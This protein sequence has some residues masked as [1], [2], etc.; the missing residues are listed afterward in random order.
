MTH[1]THLFSPTAR[2]RHRGRSRCGT[3]HDPSRHSDTPTC[4]IC[5]PHARAQALS[6]P[7][8]DHGGHVDFYE[9]ESNED[10][11]WLHPEAWGV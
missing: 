6:R 11:Y 1:R 2:R 7:N 10:D 4:Q 8:L 3:S 5:K 9:P